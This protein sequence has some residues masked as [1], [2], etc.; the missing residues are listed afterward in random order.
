MPGPSHVIV[1]PSPNDQ[2]ADTGVA[3]AVTDRPAADAVADFADHEDDEAHTH[4]GTPTSS[5]PPATG[6]DPITGVDSF[7]S[8]AASAAN[9]CAD[10]AVAVAGG[11]FVNHTTEFVEV[12][13]SPP[14]SA[15]GH[16]STYHAP[17][18]PAWVSVPAGG[19]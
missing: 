19:T 5:G 13:P 18:C 15:S 1:A 6:L 9:C 8:A 10:G 7:N 4:I 11:G 12:N 3:V 17:F 16:E 2:V 14:L